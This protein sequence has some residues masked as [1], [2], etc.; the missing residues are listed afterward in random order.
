MAQVIEFHYD[1]ANYFDSSFLDYYLYNSKRKIVLVALKDSGYYVYENVS[2][3]DIRNWINAKSAGKYFHDAD[4]SENHIAYATKVN[5][6]R[7]E[8]AKE[9][10]QVAI[11]MGVFS[12]YRPEGRNDI[13]LIKRSNVGFI[14]SIPDPF[15][16]GYTRNYSMI[17][18][19]SGFLTISINLE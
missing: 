19:G 11:D 10:L 3:E 2:T 9:M 16:P 15:T 4:W 17:S 1:N 12:T 5:A 6:V 13:V 7:H 18:S 8:N 14:I